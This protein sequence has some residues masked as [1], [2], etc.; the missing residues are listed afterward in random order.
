MELKEFVGK[1]KKCKSLSPII[2]MLKNHKDLLDIVIERTSYLLNN[3]KIIKRLYHIKHDLYEV[4]K[5]PICGNEKKWSNK[6]NKYNTT[7]D[8]RK[9]RYENSI[10][11]NPEMDINRRRNISEKQKN[12]TPEEKKIIRDKI[13]KTLINKYGVDSYAKTKE[14]KNFM[15]DNYGY[16]SPF[17]LKKTH[18]KS[19]QTL[20]D[21][22]GY[23]HN[24]KIPEVK[25]KRTKTFYDNYGFNTPTKN[26]KIKEKS[27]Q[28]NLDKY[29]A[30]T[31][32]Q[33]DECKEQ[34]KKTNNAIFGKDSYTQT[35]EYKERYKNTCLK[36]YKTEHWMQN[37]DNF[38]YYKECL[39]SQH[40]NTYKKYILPNNEIVYLQ[41]YE[42][43]V[44]EEIL[45]KKYKLEDILIRNKDITNHTG[46]I[47][48]KYNVML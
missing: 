46:K 38:Q 37:E 43:Y 33:T 36:N 26:D 35:D 42:D 40:R 13:V 10:L 20:I 9:C 48:Y 12:K 16:I 21:K 2:N 39:I 3:E 14:F 44:L 5:C 17:E 27:K 25:E 15:I 6:F 11:I 1:I 8:N 47:Y 24:F 4:P 22:T 29:S 31:Y 23:N 19:K 28:K 34:V 30:I 7:C 18:E 45:L 32:S 41:G